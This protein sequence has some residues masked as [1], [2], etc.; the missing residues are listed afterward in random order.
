M[1]RTLFFLMAIAAILSAAETRFV[2][3]VL[4]ATPTIDGR[5]DDSPALAVHGL[6]QYNS[7]YLSGRQGTMRFA[8]TP[9]SFYIAATTPL[10]P[11]GVQLLNRVKKNDGAVFLDDSVEL[12]LT[13]PNATAVYQ[14]IVNPSGALFTRKYP[15]D[16]G[17]TTHT[18]FQQWQH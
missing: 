7:L 9:D 1:K 3:P 17:G 6:V 5:L 15:I 16:N 13:P 14:V 8:L 10:P 11:E 12:D 2:L 18:H 4:K